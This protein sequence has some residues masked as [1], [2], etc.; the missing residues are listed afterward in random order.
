[1]PGRKKSPFNPACSAPFH[2]HD[3]I[4]DK[5]RLLPLQI[6]FLQNSPKRF[7]VGFSH[8]HQMGVVGLFEVVIER[9]SPPKLSLQICRSAAR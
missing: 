9:P 2:I 3:G 1:M 6:I 5:K 7:R 8:S 4:I